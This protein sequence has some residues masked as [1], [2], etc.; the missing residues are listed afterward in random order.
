MDHQ[1]GFTNGI[2]DKCKIEKFL[3]TRSSINVCQDYSEVDKGVSLHSTFPEISPIR[4]MMASKCS[5]GGVHVASYNQ[6]NR[7]Y[8][9]TISSSSPKS[10]AVNGK[11]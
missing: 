8:S 3:E 11:L 1:N 6:Q 4:N 10:T 5:S 7:S 9:S 2:K